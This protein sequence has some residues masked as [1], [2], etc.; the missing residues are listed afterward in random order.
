MLNDYDVFD[1]HQINFDV[2]IKLLAPLSHIGESVGNQSNL[3]TIAVTDLEGV[4]NQVFIYSGN[5][6]RNGVLRRRGVDDFLES[7][8]LSVKP[9]VHQTLF[10]GGYID[11]GT[12]C[13]LELDK[14]I[15]QLL[16]PISVLGTAKPKGLLG[17]KDAQMIGGRLAVGD[18]VLVCYESAEYVYKYFPPAIPNDALSGLSQVVEAKLTAQNDRI[19]AWLKS[20]DRLTNADSNYRELL[21]EWQPYLEEK[22][23]PYTQWLTWNQKVRMDSLKA[24][25]LQ[26][27][28]QGSQREGQLSLLGADTTKEKP[29]KSDTKQQMI[30]GDWLIQQGA[31]LYSRWSA[32]IT[33]IEEGFIASALLKFAESPY[34]GGK[35]GTG[36][37]LVSIDVYSKVNG[38]SEHWL[39]IS[40]TSQVIGDRAKENHQRYLSYLEDYKGYLE[41]LKNS[42]I[43]GFLGL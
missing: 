35:S 27:F 31:T 4:S 3:K 21:R 8:K 30:M 24:P 39:H 10:A 42:D 32:N 41:D 1:R 11:G 5:A 16:P 17:G 34:L 28:L 14:K 13:D 18:A 43:K 33:D 40:P 19:E 36:C 22:L 2:V 29:K 12:G 23:R 20:G 6:L 26:K 25:E 37:G 38:N 9:E 7:L 15:R